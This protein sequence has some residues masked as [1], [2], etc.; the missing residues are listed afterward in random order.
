MPQMSLNIGTVLDE[1]YRLERVLG[2]GG[3][4]ITYQATDLRLDHSVAIKEYFPGYC[5]SRMTEVSD[6]IRCDIG[7][8]RE[9]LKGLDR[10]TK[11]AKMLA[12]LYGLVHVVRV[13]DYFEANATGYIV[14]DYVEG[15]N[16]K[17]MADSFGG[18]IRPDM[19][20]Y[21]MEP[22]IS[23]LWKVHQ[24]GLIHRDISPDNVMIRP[25]GSVCLID[26]GNARNSTN[27]QSM[28]VTLKHGF[29][30][31][32]QY[33]TRGQGL[34]TDVYGVC[35]TIYYC[36]TG[37]VPTRA[38]DRLTGKP[39]VRPSELGVFMPPWQEQAIMDGLELQINRRIQNMDV[40]WTRLYKQAAQG[41]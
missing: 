34:Y 15:K 10:F 32:E 33:S 18:R 27:E 29:A 8:E 9:Y 40:L 14:M 22:V 38:M 1:R 17:Q 4:G 23:A 13:T 28:T 31:P 30:A 6:D 3:Y 12:Q 36:L 25:D 41:S 35:A 26:F 19:L 39:L 16:L 2:A 7:A 24:K 5:A 20:L 11:E 21:L 37:K